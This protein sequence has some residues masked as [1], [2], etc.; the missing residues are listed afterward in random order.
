MIGIPRRPADG[1]VTSLEA[2]RA[3]GAERLFAYGLLGAFA[4]GVGVRAIQTLGA[5]FP[6]NDGGMFFQMVRD[7]QHSRFGFPS[8]TTYN[9]ADIPF[10]YPPLALYLTAIL[11]R[12]TPFGLLFWFR[13]LPL[14]FSSLTILAVYRLARTVLSSRTAVLGSVVAF[15]LI[16]RS[17]IWL[18]MGGGLTRSLGMLLAILALEQVYQLYTKGDRRYLAA[19]AVLSAGTVLSHPETGWSLAFS[20][21]VFWAVLGRNRAGLWNSAFLASGTL[22]LTAPWWLAVIAQHGLGPFLAANSTGGTVFS[23]GSARDLAFE[24][25]ARA[26]ATSEPYFPVIGALG[27]LGA[28]A[29]LA[30][31]RFLL[32]AWWLAI[33]LLDVRAFATYSSVP[34]AL[35]AGIAVAEG[36]IPLL[37][38]ADPRA[39]TAA[40]TPHNEDGLPHL[41][42]SGVVL[43]T[44][45]LYY[46]TASD[47]MHSSTSEM[48]SLAALNSDEREAFAWVAN[49]TPASSRFLVVP[50]T[51]WQTDRVS[52]WF[53]ALTGRV[54]VATVQGTEW[55]PGRSFAAMIGVHAYAQYCGYTDAKCVERWITETGTQVDY[56]YVPSSR[57]HPCCGGLTESLD[58]GPDY[59]RLYTG[60]GGIVFERL[61]APPITLPGGD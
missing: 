25:I 41:R 13:F 10:A 26:V 21:G 15:A 59:R 31:R 11:D 42:W 56:I 58:Q 8:T 4:L 46:A 22:A 20:I 49:S 23:D 37:Q 48:S 60:A 43:L 19:A 54:S 1:A 2:L 33:I 53:P 9:Q 32:P 51:A 17:F 38:R 18:I 50:T 52:E 55:L 14:L 44:C 5:D 3:P 28:A 7:I 6:L 39:R 57:E 12:I 47:F 61:P 35:L 36:L 34:V 29:C 45:L 40:G 27:L 24:S 16:P 30:S